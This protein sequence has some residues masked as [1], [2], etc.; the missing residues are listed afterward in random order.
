MPGLSKLDRESLV[1]PS[2]VAGRAHSGLQQSLQDRTSLSRVE[3]LG[4]PES[5]PVCWICPTDLLPA[6]PELSF[7]LLDRGIFKAHQLGVPISL[8]FG[9]QG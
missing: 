5:D 3:G 1:P 2:W 7:E 4:S 9:C 6:L 8:V